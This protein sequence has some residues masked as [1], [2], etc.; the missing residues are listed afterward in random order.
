MKIEIEL[1]PKSYDITVAALREGDWFLSRG[2]PCCVISWES[3]CSSRFF[4][5]A[6][7][8]VTGLIVAENGTQ[9]AFWKPTD[10]VKLI[11]SMR[12]IVET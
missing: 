2:C 11:K 5:H 3:A 8:R 1:L 7:E 4:G 10:T 9:V 12:L 6:D